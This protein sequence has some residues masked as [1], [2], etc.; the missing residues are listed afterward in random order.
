MNNKSNFILKAG[1]L[2]LIFSLTACGTTGTN[3]IDNRSDS[4]QR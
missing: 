1:L 4:H 2:G 3:Y